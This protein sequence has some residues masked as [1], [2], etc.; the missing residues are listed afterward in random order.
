MINRTLRHSLLKNKN[1]FTLIELI[2]TMAVLTIFMYLI[3][4]IVQD[5][6]GFFRDEETQVA[7]QA[8]LRIV[9]VQ[10]EKDIRRHVIGSDE[11]A[12]SGDCFLIQPVYESDVS[13]CKV[14]D[15]I[16][17]NGIVVARGVDTFLA[18]YRNSDNSILLTL[19]SFEDGYGRVNEV[20]VR[21]FVRVGS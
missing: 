19:R 16:E 8:A 17:R 10:F 20:V 3:T 4:M 6:L 13:Y 5:S 11:F 12:V 2:I 15:N 1:G 18:S 7:N 14:G 21:I 9:A